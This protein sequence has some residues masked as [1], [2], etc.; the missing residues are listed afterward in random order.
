MDKLILDWSRCADGV[1]VYDRGPHELPSSPRATYLQEP[2]GLWYR[3]RSKTYVP[4]HY[5]LN[6]LE[7]EHGQALIVRFVNAHTPDKLAAFFTTYG[8]IAH[9]AQQASAVEVGSHQRGMRK[10]LQAAGE[11]GAAAVKAVNAALVDAQTYPPVPQL[12]WSPGES[13]PRFTLRLRSLLSFM[14]LEALL[15]AASNARL[16]TCQHDRVLFLT[17][18][19]TGRRS[20]AKFCSDRCRVAAMR[21]RR[22]A[23]A[24]QHG[25]K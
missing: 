8:M 17:G 22:L 6:N 16:A 21:A 20:H 7:G 25:R 14:R 1:E 18:P 4:V 13:S 10:L 11:G 2:D 3:P 24:K 5:E 19:L 9:A 23:E 12:T 15:I